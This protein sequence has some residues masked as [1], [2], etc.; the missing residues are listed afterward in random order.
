MSPLNKKGKE[1]MQSM[2]ETYKDPKKAKSVFYA[3]V[4][5]GKIKG[6]EGKG[7]KSK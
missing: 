6:V 2:H 3:S 5:A 1:I 7:G 4:N